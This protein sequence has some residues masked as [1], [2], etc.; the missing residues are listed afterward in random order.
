MQLTLEAKF[1]QRVKEKS[2]KAITDVH[3][4]CMHAARH[5]SMDAAPLDAL[6]EVR[7]AGKHALL[8][9]NAGSMKWGRSCLSWA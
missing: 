8:Q 2:L 5:H 3:R 6:A 7:I 1:G 4:A 9:A